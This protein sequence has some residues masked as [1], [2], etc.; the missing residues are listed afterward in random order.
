[1]AELLLQ[2]ANAGQMRVQA[3]LVLRGHARSQR[4]DVGGQKIEHALAL[5]Q[6]LRELRVGQI[7][8]VKDA[9]VHLPRIIDR[10]VRLIR[11]A[12]GDHAQRLLALNLHAEL[13]RRNL[14]W[15]RF[16]RSR[17]RVAWNSTFAPVCSSE[18]SRRRRWA[19][20]ATNSAGVAGS[21]SPSS[22]PSPIGPDRS[23]GRSARRHSAR[24]RTRTSDRRA[25]SRVPRAA[26][27]SHAHVARARPVRL[28]VSARENAPRSLK[29]LIWRTLEPMSD[30]ADGAAGPR[31]GCPSR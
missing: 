28:V 17:A 3:C 14:S 13:E 15:C 18:R 19:S 27:R 2:A 1:M 5:G 23:V 11:A 25:G 20:P 22:C 10:D 26:C 29:S 24:S 8:V 21:R 9:R 6:E 4:G 31:A 16:A 7:G 30:G 12:I